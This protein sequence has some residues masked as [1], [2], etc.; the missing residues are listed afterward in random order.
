MNSNQGRKRGN[1]E[2][3]RKRRNH[4]CRFVRNRSTSFAV[5]VSFQQ[6]L[7]RT[8]LKFAS[9]DPISLAFAIYEPCY[10]RGTK[11][12]DD[13][14]L[15]R[16]A[17]KEKKGTTAKRRLQRAK[18][19]RKTQ[20]LRFRAPSSISP[21]SHLRPRRDDREQCERRDERD[22]GGAEHCV[23]GVFEEGGRE[24]TTKKEKDEE[25]KENCESKKKSTAKTKK[26]LTFPSPSLTRARSSLFLTNSVPKEEK[27]S[28]TSAL[29][30]MS[31]ER[32]PERDNNVIAL[33]SS[34]SSSS[35]TMTLNVFGQTVRERKLA[36]SKL[37]TRLFFS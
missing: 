11:E 34:A 31:V 17:T 15:S 7:S 1:C 24:R 10:F 2:R 13:R 26:T 25:K 36:C 28:H 5:V 9:F 12:H 6:L 19:K 35:P 30:L 33:T 18:R 23:V 8:A 22:C 16:P 29:I 32:S 4:N 14:C 27:D 3:K 21:S 37:V 20:P